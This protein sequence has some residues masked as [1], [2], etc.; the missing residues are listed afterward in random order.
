MDIGYMT[1]MLGGRDEESM[2][3]SSSSRYSS[4]CVCMRET[5]RERGRDREREREREK[6]FLYVY[7][8][9][10][11]C[12]LHNAKGEGCGTYCGVII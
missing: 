8:Y 5:E 12:A 10:C 2:Y 9:V 1:S 3:G 6:V 4:T 7:V 11:V